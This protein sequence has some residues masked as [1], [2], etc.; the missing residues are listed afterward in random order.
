M[1]L[2]C[3][4]CKGTNIAESIPNRCLDCE[5]E[6]QLERYTEKEILEAMTR[7]LLDNAPEYLNDRGA[8]GEH[9]KYLRKIS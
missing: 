8:A 4:E 5:K 7:F 9:G 1:I 3:K 6:V 2:F